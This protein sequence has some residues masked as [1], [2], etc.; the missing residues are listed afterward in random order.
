MIDT[1]SL[2]GDNEVC[3][4]AFIP[5]KSEKV[6]WV[7]HFTDIDIATGQE[8]IDKTIDFAEKLWLGEKCNKLQVERLGLSRQRYWGCP[9]PVVHCDSCG[10]VP[11]KKNLLFLFQMM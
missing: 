9:I 5:P 10:V 1:F 11:E 8:A 6:K 2:N 7:N 3:D 4:E